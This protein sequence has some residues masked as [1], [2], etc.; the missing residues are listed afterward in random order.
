MDVTITV[1]STG[2]KTVQKNKVFALIALY[3]IG[4]SLNKKNRLEYII[5]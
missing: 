2:Y 1:L 5:D 4:E 3:F